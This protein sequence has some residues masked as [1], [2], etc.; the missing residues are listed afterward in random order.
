MKLD[1]IDPNELM[2]DFYD[3]SICGLCCKDKDIL[4]IGED[5]K[6]ISKYLDISYQDFFNNY[7]IKTSKKDILETYYGIKNSSE[8]RDNIKFGFIKKLFTSNRMIRVPCKFLQN[9][10]CKIYDVRPTACMIF[11]VYIYKKDNT[12]EIGSVYKCPLATHFFE[13]LMEFTKIYFPVEYKKDIESL[14]KT[15]EIE[16]N[17]MLKLE[18]YKMFSWYIKDKKVFEKYYKINYSKD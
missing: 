3:C 12:F 14:K 10:R 6:K 15:N 13:G 8:L 1:L 9:N 17:I 11:P 4:I 16:L 5:L 2:P 7:T 18:Y